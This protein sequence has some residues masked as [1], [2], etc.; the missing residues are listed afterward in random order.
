LCNALVEKEDALNH[1]HVFEELTKLGLLKDE[2]K[3]PST[4]FEKIVKVLQVSM[5]S[6]VKLSPKPKETTVN[7]PDSWNPKPSIPPKISKF[8]L[9]EVI[10]TQKSTVQSKDVV[11]I[12]VHGVSLQDPLRHITE[13][14]FPQEVHTGLASLNFR[15]IYRTQSHSWPNLLEG[16]SLFLV[17][18]ENSGKTFS[19][20]PA[21]ISSI[22]YDKDD[23]APWAAGPVGIIIVGSSK[24]VENIFRIAKKLVNSENFTIVKAFGNWNCENKKVDLLNSCELL[25][26][27]PACFS[28]LAVGDVFAMF[29]KKRI[30]HLVLDGIDTM[31]DVGKVIATCTDTRPELNPQIVVTSSSWSNKIRRLMKLTCDPI[32]IIGGFTEA[33]LYAK[34]H[35]AIS[36]DSF[37]EKLQRL[38]QA[39]RNDVEVKTLVAFNNESEVRYIKDFLKNR[40]VGRF[41]SIDETTS[42]EDTE[43][44]KKEWPK[45]GAEDMKIML[46]TDYAL[47]SCNF[48]CAKRLIH[49]S[50]PGNWTTFSKRFAVMSE[51]FLDLV[52]GSGEGKT[53][54]IIML[55]E[56]NAT[57]IPRLIEFAKTRGVLK[58]VPD[59]IE[60]LVEVRK[61]RICYFKML[62]SSIFPLQNLIEKREKMKRDNDEDI[63]PLCTNILQFGYCA[64]F[65]NCKK[66]HVLVAADKSVNIPCDGLMK[67]E[68]VAVRSAAHYTMKVLEYLP[69]REKRWISCELKTQK[70]EK[71]LETLQE[72]MI[73]NTPVIQVPLKVG[74][75]CAVFY[76]KIAKWCRAKVIEKQ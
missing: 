28:R 65:S 39:L 44:L 11:K 43:E 42:R 61:R 3:M 72:T 24:E 21:V 34:C 62:F 37:E 69:L 1:E 16:R 59:D 48:K 76:P 73:T 54:T 4:N 50:L 47:S 75:L 10:D 30:K 38:L 32:V 18:G 55:D 49:F 29:D 56:N 36:K 14:C 53:S 15:T 9:A 68:L 17:N 66:R 58:T 74:E 60:R 23:N 57:E 71:A 35:F 26:T 6:Q 40:A 2:K 51:A 12:F 19:Y 20:L 25:I 64:K 8:S 63:A 46:A 7:S 22:T 67:F 27:T 13:A 33:A 52:G 70:I 41:V 45:E 5:S 31:T